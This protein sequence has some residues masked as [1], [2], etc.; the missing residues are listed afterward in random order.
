[1]CRFLNYLPPGALR[2]TN[3]E[4]WQAMPEGRRLT[5]H[6]EERGVKLYASVRDS[7][8]TRPGSGFFR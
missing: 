4:P 7:R 2:P 3:Y 1:M 6:C 8:L 5:L